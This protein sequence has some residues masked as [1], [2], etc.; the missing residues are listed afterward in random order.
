MNTTQNEQTNQAPPPPF[1]LTPLQYQPTLPEDVGMPPFPAQ[2]LSMNRTSVDMTSIDPFGMDYI[3]DLETG[4]WKAFVSLVFVRNSRPED[5][6][7]QQSFVEKILAQGNPLGFTPTRVSDIEVHHELG[8]LTG[9]TRG[10]CLYYTRHRSEDPHDCEELECD[11]FCIKLTNYTKLLIKYKTPRKNEFTKEEYTQ[12]HDFFVRVFNVMNIAFYQR[13]IATLQ[14]YFSRVPNWL[15]RFQEK[16]EAAKLGEEVEAVEEDKDVLEEN[17]AVTSLAIITKEMEKLGRPIP[18]Q[19]CQ[20]VVLKYFQTLLRMTAI[21]SILLAIP[22]GCVN[23]YAQYVES[24]I[25]DVDVYEM[26]YTC[27]SGIPKLT[28]T[29]TSTAAAAAG[30]LDEAEPSFLDMF[31]DKDDEENIFCLAARRCTM[32]EL[33]TVGDAKVPFDEIAS[34]NNKEAT[35]T[36]M[37]VVFDMFFSESAVE[38]HVTRLNQLTGYEDMFTGEQVALTADAFKELFAVYIDLKTSSTNFESVDDKCLVK[39]AYLSECIGDRQMV[40]QIIRYFLSYRFEYMTRLWTMEMPKVKEDLHL[41]YHFRTALQWNAI[42]ESNYG[43]DQNGRD[44]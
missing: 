36:A 14:E 33:V 32:D 2:A 26:L 28:T 43:W 8:W 10:K 9:V 30:S 20:H 22:R 34:T 3:T 40:F 29:S 5:L 23:P 7:K 35:K 19:I 42:V 41:P 12:L 27:R 39:L 25:K 4:A 1:F 24:F 38:M 17:T 15:E 6:L 16:F 44:A 37:R 13:S 31:R 18:S 11:E 21:P